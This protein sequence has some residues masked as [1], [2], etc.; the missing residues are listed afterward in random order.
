MEKCI[1]KGCKNHR[2]DGLFVGDLCKPCHVMLTE[3]RLIPSEAWFVADARK[4]ERE[5]IQQVLG[6]YLA[7][8]Q[9]LPSVALLGTTRYQKPDFETWLAYQLRDRTPNGQAA[10]TA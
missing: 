10:T 9:A 7:S 5:A 8:W 1:V 6:E 2:H 4:V 3:G